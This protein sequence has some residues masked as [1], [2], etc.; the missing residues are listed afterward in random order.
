M[1]VCCDI[2]EPRGVLRAREEEAFEMMVIRWR[3]EDVVVLVRVC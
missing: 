2:M 1:V 3:M